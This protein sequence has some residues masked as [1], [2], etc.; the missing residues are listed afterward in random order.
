MRRI[1]A[2]AVHAVVVLAGVLA[3]AGCGVVP[4]VG[5]DPRVP[6]VP[7]AAVTCPETYEE[8]YAEA[9]LVPDGFEAVAVLRCDPYAGWQ[10]AEGTWQGVRLE[11]L[12]GDL[13]PVLAALA[14]PSD[15]RSLGPCT[16]IGY[17]LPEL[18][19]EGSD[20][21]FVRL[22]I[23]V[24]G[25]GAP[26]D[27]GLDAALGALDVVA[28]T[29]TPD[30][31]VE[32]AEA[33]AAGCAS[34]AQFLVL[35]EAEDVGGSP[36]P[37]PDGIGGGALVP[38]ELPGWPD[39][40]AVRGARLCDYDDAGFTAV[41]ELAAADAQAIIAAALLAPPARPCAE[42]A[43]RAVTVQLSVAGEDAAVPSGAETVTVEL[44]GCRR[45]I[46]PTLRA[47]AATPELLALVTPAG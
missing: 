1:S 28:E 2:I 10:D 7:V 29:L 18:W 39:P 32:S 31:L 12:E 23:P 27:V 42:T 19:L 15:P 21:T 41:R 17:L 37:D 47:R 46:D 8:G 22:A 36:E 11:R 38:Y 9:G 43:A 14:K 13:E 40:A 44:D 20:G 26:K 33:L 35:A 3:L 16:A 6:A 4:A 25:C 24:N 5:P 45:L 34:T 30:A